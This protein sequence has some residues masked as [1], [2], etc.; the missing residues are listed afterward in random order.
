[1]ALTEFLQNFPYGETATATEGWKPGVTHEYVKLQTSKVI[2]LRLTSDES[3]VVRV[4]NF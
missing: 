3:C 4:L 1:M 2:T